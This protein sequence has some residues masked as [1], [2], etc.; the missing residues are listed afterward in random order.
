VIRTFRYVIWPDVPRRLALGWF[1]AGDLGAPHGRYSV[2]MERICECG[3][4]AD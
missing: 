1:I 3:R 2:L 4:M